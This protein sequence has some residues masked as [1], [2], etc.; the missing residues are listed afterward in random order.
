MSEQKFL[1]LGY[2]IIDK[3][4]DV[5]LFVR[6]PRQAGASDH[7][8]INSKDALRQFLENLCA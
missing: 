4:G 7:I 6:Y 3:K 1:E 8:L 5:L 2:E